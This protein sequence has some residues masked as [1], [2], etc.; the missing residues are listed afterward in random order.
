M[1]MGREKIMSGWERYVGNEGC[2]IG[3]KTFGASAPL[4]ELQKYAGRYIA[5]SWDGKKILADGQDEGDVRAKLIAAGLD[6]QLVVYDY[7]DDI[8]NRR[9]P[10]REE[11]LELVG[12]LHESGELIMAGAFT[13]A[14]AHCFVPLS[15]N[16]ITRPCSRSFSCRWMARSRGSG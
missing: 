1:E 5:F 15:E 10:F 11:H 12:S 7:V 16:P 9:V 13:I 8:V 6:P 2:V 3:M 4:K 14:Y